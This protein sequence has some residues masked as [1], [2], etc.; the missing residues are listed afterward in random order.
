MLYTVVFWLF[1]VIFPADAFGSPAAVTACSGFHSAASTYCGHS[2]IHIG[3]DVTASTR[4]KTTPSPINL[5]SLCTHRHSTCFS[6]HWPS[7]AV[8]VCTSTVN[9]HAL[10]LFVDFKKASIR[11]GGWSCN[12]LDEFG[13]PVKVAVL[14]KY[15]CMNRLVTF[16]WQMYVWHISYWEWSATRR[17]LVGCWRRGMWHGGRVVVGKLTERDKLEVRGLDGR[18]TLN[19]ILKE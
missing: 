13:L 14:I 12:I 15:V 3:R 18:K 19:W 4:T 7:R 2:F 8:Q 9:E 11:S 16:G 6:L 17:V 1:V 5:G 10:E